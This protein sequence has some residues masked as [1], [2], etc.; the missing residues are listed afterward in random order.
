VIR[1][2]RL[3]PLIGAAVLA[4]GC[5]GGNETS[6]TTDWFNNV[7]G[8]ITTWQ[9]SITAAGQSL[10]DNPSKDGL[11]SAYADAKDATSTLADDLKSAGK[12]D[13]QAG[14]QA[15]QEL[16]TLATQLDDG[17]AQMQDAVGGVS[18][19]NEALTAV[20]AVSG[21][22]ATMGT[23]VKSTVDNIRALDS[24]GEL[25]SAFDQADACAPLKS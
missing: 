23:Q 21:T 10:K 15:K 7:C 16:D 11:E 12:P 3:A 19:V 8:S 13:T 6:A 25:Q 9:D 1:A 24:Q 17:V 20:S 4:A 5:G 18:T 14:D 22:L 2:T